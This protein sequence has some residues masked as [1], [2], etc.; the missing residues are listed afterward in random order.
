[1]IPEAIIY[2]KELASAGGPISAV[3]IYYYARNFFLS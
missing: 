2:H 1:M 3:A